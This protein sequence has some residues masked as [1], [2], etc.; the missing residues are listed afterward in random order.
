MHSFTS[1]CSRSILISA[2]V[3]CAAVGAQTKITPDKEAEMLLKALS[4]DRNLEKRSGSAINIGVLYTG[5]GEA[6]A[7]AVAAAFQRAG[8]GGGA[9]LPV[10]ATTIPFTSVSALLKKVEGENINALYVHPSLSAALSSVQQ[11]SRG[12]KILSL[13]GSKELVERGLSVGVYMGKSAPRLIVNMKAGTVEGLDLKPA[14]RLVAK[15]VK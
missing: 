15:V 2:I 3:L 8:K 10:T 13:G 9:P 11:V 4:Y 7:A 14:I 12:R 1:W 5:D 6:E